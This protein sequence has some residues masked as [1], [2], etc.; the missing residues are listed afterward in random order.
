M[1]PWA[2]LLVG[3]AEP[4]L[5]KILHESWVEKVQVHPIY[6]YIYACHVHNY[7]FNIYR[8]VYVSCAYGPVG[9]TVGGCCRADFDEDITRFLGRE[10]AGASYIYMCIYIYI[11]M[12]CT[13]LYV[14]I[15]IYIYVLYAYGP[16]GSVVGGCCR[17]NFD[18]ETTRFLGGES[19]GKLYTNMEIYRCD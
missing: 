18:E 14:N 19:T 15:Y 12:P 17:A 8:Y 7:M 16:V 10:S 3:A 2:R 13:Q 9:S 4:I 5:T 6:I 1:V 11:C